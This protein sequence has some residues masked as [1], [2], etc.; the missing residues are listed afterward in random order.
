[1]SW[2]NEIIA[3]GAVLF[4]GWTAWEY[5]IKPELE[6]KKQKSSVAQSSEP[7]KVEVIDAEFKEAPK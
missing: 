4:L 6:R 1:M 3:L 2:L 5:K 7:R